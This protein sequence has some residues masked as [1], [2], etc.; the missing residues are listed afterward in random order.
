MKKFSF[1]EKV[2]KYGGVG[3]WHFVALPQ[4]LSDEVKEASKNKKKVAWSYIKVK[5]TIGKTTWLTTLFPGKV[6]P[7]LLA[8]KAQV[9]HAEGIREDDTV[10]VSCTLL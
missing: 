3:G 4:K 7:C 2:F 1:T 9:R 5:A 8:I 6:Y 10:K